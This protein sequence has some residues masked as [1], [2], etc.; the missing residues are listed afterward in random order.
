MEGILPL[1]VI[2]LGHVVPSVSGRPVSSA[3]GM[4]MLYH[5]NLINVRIIGRS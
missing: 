4:E 2:W 1:E 3:S 5:K